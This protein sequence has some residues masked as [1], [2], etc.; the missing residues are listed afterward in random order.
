MLCFGCYARELS[1]LV[2]VK[3]KTALD[4]HFHCVFFGSLLLNWLLH[5][6][7]IIPVFLTFISSSGCNQ[8]SSSSR[9]SPLLGHV[10]SLECNL[11]RVSHNLRPTFL[12][13]K[14]HIVSILVCILS[15][16]CWKTSGRISLGDFASLTLTG[17]CGCS[18]CRRTKFWLVHAFASDVS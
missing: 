15:L 7:H 8:L 6:L 17:K 13:C 1:C 14:Y 9:L 11:L 5:F 2:E 10:L 3:T 18:F 12:P 4:A 16:G